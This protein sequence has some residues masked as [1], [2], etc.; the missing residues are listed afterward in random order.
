MAA[1]PTMATPM[2][3]HAIEDQWCLYNFFFKKM[4]AIMAVMIMIIPLSI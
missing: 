1:S 4:M 2:K 3:M